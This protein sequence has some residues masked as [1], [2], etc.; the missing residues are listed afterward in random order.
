MKQNVKRW[1]QNLPDNHALKINVFATALHF[2]PL[3]LLQTT[4]KYQ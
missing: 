4:E 3:T 2:K 1:K